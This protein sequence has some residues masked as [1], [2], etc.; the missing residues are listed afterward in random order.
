MFTAIDFVEFNS[1]VTLG[2]TFFILIYLFSE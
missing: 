2:S 1:I